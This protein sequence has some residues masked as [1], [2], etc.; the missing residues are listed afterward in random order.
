[1]DDIKKNALDPRK[2]ASM[3]IQEKRIDNTLF[4]ELGSRLVFARA[5]DPNAFLISVLEE[6]AANKNV[7]PTQFFT[8]TDVLHLFVLSRFSSLPT[9]MSRIS[10][11]DAF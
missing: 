1:M 4:Q 7:G 6:M 8:D 2:D 10:D 9:T 3:Y 11:C 5:S